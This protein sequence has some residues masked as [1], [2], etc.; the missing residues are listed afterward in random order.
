MGI[1]GKV[2]SRYAE[3]TQR[4]NKQQSDVLTRARESLLWLDCLSDVSLD[5]SAREGVHEETGFGD[6]IPTIFLRQCFGPA[7]Q[8][9]GGLW[10]DQCSAVTGMDRQRSRDF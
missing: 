3:A 1:S 6:L 10:F 7:Y 9:H 4:R 5:G 2:F 8:N